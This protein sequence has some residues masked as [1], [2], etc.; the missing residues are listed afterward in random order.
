MSQPT[1]KTPL[2]GTLKQHA[3]GYYILPYSFLVVVCFSCNLV[4]LLPTHVF[5][6]VFPRHSTILQLCV[7]VV[8]DYIQDILWPPLGRMLDYTAFSALYGQQSLSVRRLIRKSDTLNVILKGCILKVPAIVTTIIVALRQ[9]GV[10]TWR[11]V[12]IAVLCPS[13]TGGIAFVISVA[14][15]RM[16]QSRKSER[17]DAL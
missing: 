6:V 13:L 3:S 5:E 12:M 2:L 11:S 9:A 4:P 16:V 7:L 17:D 8:P 1:D 14:S 15:V 10:P